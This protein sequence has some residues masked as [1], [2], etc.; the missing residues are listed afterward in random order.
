M[1]YIDFNEYGSRKHL[2]SSKSY[3]YKVVNV[4]AGQLKFVSS[5]SYKCLA[6]QHIRREYEKLG[7]LG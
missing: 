6:G 5:K 4:M 3:S 1:F 2:V 7:V